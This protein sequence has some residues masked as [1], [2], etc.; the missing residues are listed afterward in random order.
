MWFHRPFRVDEW[1]WYGQRSP[2]YTGGRGTCLGEVYD[3][4][5]RLVATCAQEV[6]LR[7]VITPA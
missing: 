1:L 2:V 5:G 7:Y 4:T 6:S 3:A